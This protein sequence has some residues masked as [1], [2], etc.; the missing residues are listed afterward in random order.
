MR[1][2]EPGSHPQPCDSRCSRPSTGPGCP[3]TAEKQVP[4]LWH[5]VVE[6]SCRPDLSSAELPALPPAP[7]LLSAQTG[8][9]RVIMDVNMK[10]PAWGWMRMWRVVDGQQTIQAAKLNLRECGSVLSISNTLKKNRIP[11]TQE[12]GKVGEP[13]HPVQS[14]ES[15]SIIPLLSPWAQQCLNEHQRPRVPEPQATP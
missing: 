13:F 1:R 11:R 5:G 14:M 9:P 8:S 6:R 12:K 10:A 3:L 2:S 7:T 4:L 15:K